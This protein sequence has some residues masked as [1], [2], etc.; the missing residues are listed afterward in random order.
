MF[1]RKTRVND[2]DHNRQG[3]A[4]FW[5]PIQQRFPDDFEKNF[6]RTYLHELGHT[7]NLI[8]TFEHSLEAAQ[9]SPSV[10]NYPEAFGAGPEVF[11]R[12]F[13]FRFDDA[14]SRFL[15]HGRCWSRDFGIWANIGN[16]LLVLMLWCSERSIWEKYREHDVR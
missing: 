9:T 3:A 13:D 2:D 16:S 11:L 15:Y 6:K 1:D 4:V 12:Q 7:F 5:E 14:E 10:M 8:H